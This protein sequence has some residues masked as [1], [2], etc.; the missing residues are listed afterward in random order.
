MNKGRFYL[1]L[2]MALLSIMVCAQEQT[3]YI[4][5]FSADGDVC[6]PVRVKHSRGEFTFS[7]NGYRVDGPINYVEAWDCQGRKILDTTPDSGGGYSTDKNKPIVYEYVFT[8]LYP[9]SPNNNNSY[10]DDID[11]SQDYNN[12]TNSPTNG[13]NWIEDLGKK[14]DVGRHRYDP[15][16]SN[17][18]FQAGLS[19]VHGEFVRAKACLGGMTGF[20]LYGGIGK[21]WVFDAKNEDFIG[22]DAKKFC[23]HAGMGFYGGDLN[24]VTTNGEFALLMDYADSPLAKGGTLNIWLEGTWYFAA[25]G[26]FGAFGGIGFSWGN[27]KDEKHP[28]TNFIFEVGLAV[29]FF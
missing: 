17:I 15:A 2:L 22:P 28:I 19:K 7:Y 14:V 18:T 4:N 27:I 16:Y 25:K 26:H 3:Q 10:Q 8:Q 21:D 1:V 24:G 13:S 9:Q 23:W 11:Y 29:R 6:L 12:Q 5:Y 20:V